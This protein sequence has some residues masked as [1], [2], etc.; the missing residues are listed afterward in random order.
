MSLEEGRLVKGGIN[1]EAA[2]KV[3]RAINARAN[4]FCINGIIIMVIVKLR[5][6]KLLC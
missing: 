2:V 5:R 3:D 4:A 6:I 1:V